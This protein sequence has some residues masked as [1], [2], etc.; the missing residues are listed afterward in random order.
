MDG[1]MST[2]HAELAQ[3]REAVYRFLAGVFGH[4]PS[5]ALVE[6]ALDGSLVEQFA[7]LGDGEGL[8]GLRRFAASGGAADPLVASLEV[9]Y[10]G[11]FVLPSA[12]RAQP[13]ESVYRDPEQRLGGPLTVAVE[14]AYRRAGAEPSFERLHVV[15]HLSMEM[16]FM[17]FLCAREREA[18]E[19]GEAEAA[20]RCLELQREFLAEHLGRWV[21]DF[22]R[23]V[24]ERATTE[25]YPALAAIAHA[26]LRADAE[27][28]GAMPARLAPPAGGTGDGGRL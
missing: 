9:E 22:A 1:T 27:D 21:G 14:R 28:L 2:E 12:G 18:W 24:R 8:A 20:R 4:P 6:R 23:D 26:F 3:S 15:D 16:D 19:A 5:R 25:F 7:P 11:L 17:A 10:T 13:F